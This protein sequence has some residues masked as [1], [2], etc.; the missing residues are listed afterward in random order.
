MDGNGKCDPTSVH[1]AAPVI[2]G[3]KYILQRW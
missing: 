3:R 1:E 2:A